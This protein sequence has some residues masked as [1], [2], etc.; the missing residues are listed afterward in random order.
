MTHS[1]AKN[2]NDDS[3]GA[4]TPGSPDNEKSDGNDINV[5]SIKEEKASNLLNSSPMEHL[6]KEGNF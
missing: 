1:S 5:D 6:T 4:R 2:S 3:S